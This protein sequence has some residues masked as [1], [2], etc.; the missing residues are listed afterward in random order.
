MLPFQ[1]TVAQTSETGPLKA[2]LAP[3]DAFHLRSEPCLFT[4]VAKL[5]LESCCSSVQVSRTRP[6]L[7]Y[8]EPRSSSCSWVYEVLL[9]LWLGLTCA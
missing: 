2:R 3:V 6:P 4:P 8:P 5:A 9:Q 7:L 1:L